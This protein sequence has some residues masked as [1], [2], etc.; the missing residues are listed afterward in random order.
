MFYIPLRR[1]RRVVSCQ[2]TTRQDKSRKEQKKAR[3]YNKQ[4]GQWEWRYCY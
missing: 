4:T 1:G 2:W 3:F